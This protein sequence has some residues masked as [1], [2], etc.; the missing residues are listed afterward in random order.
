MVAAKVVLGALRA[1]DHHGTFDRFARAAG[2]A[3]RLEIIQMTNSLAPRPGGSITFAV[4]D[5]GRSV[6][7]LAISIA[8]CITGVASTQTLIPDE[9]GQ[10]AV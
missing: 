8:R 5:A 7:A 4:R 2:D 3:E 10:V 6:P 9:R 1:R